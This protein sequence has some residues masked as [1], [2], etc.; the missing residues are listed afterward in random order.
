M[1]DIFL[2]SICRENVVIC[3]FNSLFTIA[4]NTENLQ[5][6]TYKGFK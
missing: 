3:F 6:T 5:E 2:L 4:S 1:K